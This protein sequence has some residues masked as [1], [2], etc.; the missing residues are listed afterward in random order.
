MQEKQGI[1]LV[2]FMGAGKSS[3]GKRLAA[4][5]QLPLV[6]T[7]ALIEERTGRKIGDIFAQ[8]GES[9]FRMLETELLASLAGRVAVFATGG[10]IVTRPENWPLLKQLGLVVHLHGSAE[11]L[12]DRVKHETHRPLLRTENPRE[13]FSALLQ[14]REALYKQADLVVDTDGR[15]PEMIVDEILRSLPDGAS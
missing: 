8:D 1:V 10:G 3:V 4:A 12:F 6:D 15:T 11:I 14:T 13:T 5:L 9:A 7:D 2:G